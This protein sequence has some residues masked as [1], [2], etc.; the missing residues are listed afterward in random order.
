M[1]L[2]T[3]LVTWQGWWLFRDLGEPGSAWPV[4]G[5]A[6]APMAVIALLDSQRIRRCW[7]VRSFAE[8]YDLAALPIALGL[9][10]WVF[11]ANGVSDGSASP[12]PYL[13]LANPLDLASAGALLLLL[14]RFRRWPGTTALLPLVTMLLAAT[15]FYWLN[16]V[17]LRTLHHWAGVPFDFDLMMRSTL[18]QASLSLFWAS[19]AL[20]AMLFATR[21][22]LR[23]IWLF[24]GALMALVVAKL[25][26]VDLAGAGS[27]ERIVSFIGVGLLLLV[28]GY[29]SPVPPKRQEAS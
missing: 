15:T 29:F 24:G 7:P 21:R 19:M 14:N 1:L 10:F 8:A 26:L 20:L 9:W 18:V 23:A 28:I 4:L 17:L 11:L 22:R 3:G 13:P 2:T 5:W 27:V 6:L 16:G 12:L 25:F